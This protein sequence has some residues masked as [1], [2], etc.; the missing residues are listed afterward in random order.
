VSAA[1]ISSSNV[2][3]SPS[4]ALSANSNGVSTNTVINDVKAKEAAVRPMRAGR[5]AV[6]RS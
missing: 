2:C 6:K 3:A 1:A 4:S 5:Q